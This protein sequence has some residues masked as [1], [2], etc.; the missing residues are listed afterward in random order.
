MKTRILKTEHEYEEACAKVY[1][2]MHSSESDIEPESPEGKE[3]EFLSL[4]I[5]KYEQE[6]HSM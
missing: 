2:L 1:S 4:L 5:E 6:N 3:I